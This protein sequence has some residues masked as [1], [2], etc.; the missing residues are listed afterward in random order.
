MPHMK[1]TAKMQPV[2][3]PSPA[4]VTM[5]MSMHIGA[6]AKPIV[7]AGDLVKVGQVIAEGDGFVSAPVHASVSGKVKKLDDI[8]LSNGSYITTVVIES[9]GEDAIYEGLAPHPVED[10]L[11]R[12]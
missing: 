3:M 6:P 1:N 7:K 2:V 4:I 5:P 9:D 12:Y 8:L 10:L 11:H